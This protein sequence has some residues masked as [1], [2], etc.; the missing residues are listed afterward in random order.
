MSV[1]RKNL[2]SQVHCPILA[3]AQDTV[4]EHQMFAN[5]LGESRGS[6]EVLLAHEAVIIYRKELTIIMR[7]SEKFNLS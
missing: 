2:E 7:L 1:D 6:K 5:A 4:E 3:R